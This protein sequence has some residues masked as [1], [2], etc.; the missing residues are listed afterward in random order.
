MVI[1]SIF[2]VVKANGDSAY[3][4]IHPNASLMEARSGP[5]RGKRGCDACLFDL[6]G[7]ISW[8]RN[9]VVEYATG[10]ARRV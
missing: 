9:W 5:H 3:C 2:S 7:P 4:P 10:K 1:T 6:V 8:K